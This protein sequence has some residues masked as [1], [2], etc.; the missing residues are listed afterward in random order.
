[1]GIFSP[2][3][4]PRVTELEFQKVRSALRTHHF[5]DLDMEKVEGIF[6]GDLYEPRDIDKGIDRGEIARTIGWMREHPAVHKMSPEKVDTLERE[7]LRW[8]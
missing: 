7:L 6:R 3:P 5:T 8:V 4:G 1:M 2:T